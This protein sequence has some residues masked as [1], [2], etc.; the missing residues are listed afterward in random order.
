[1]VL[2]IAVLLFHISPAT[3]KAPP[4]DLPDDVESS[5][6]AS[7]LFAQNL[8]DVFANVANV[9]AVSAVSATAQANPGAAAS[10]AS[11]ESSAGTSSL[12]PLDVALRNSQSLSMI[13]V[14]EFQSKPMRFIS[15]ESLP[16]RR[17]WIALSIA[18]HAAAAFDAYTTRDGIAHGAIE[19]DP[20]MRPFAHSPGLYAAIQI[21]PVVLDLAARRMQRSENNFIRRTWW[22]PQSISTGMFL[23]SGVH[24]I[25]VANQR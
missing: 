7:V 5:A 17:N 15:A 11:G 16:S 23:V 9:A 12:A 22:L 10:N 1:M 20:F 14:P 4:A 24:N 21:C 3:Q 8:P 19:Q 2:A 18:Q 13:R 6:S 25:H